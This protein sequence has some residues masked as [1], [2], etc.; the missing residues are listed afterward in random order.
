MVYVYDSRSSF[1]ESVLFG[2]VSYVN[3]ASESWIFFF[4]PVE[5]LV[6]V[7]KIVVLIDGADIVVSSKL[8]HVSH[9]DDASD[10]G[11]RDGDLV[12]DEVFAVD[13][14]RSACIWSSNHHEDSSW[15]G[16]PLVKFMQGC[17]FNIESRNN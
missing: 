2:P 6:E 4:Q 12:V 9:V 16:Q 15:L 8:E 10:I 7:L 17:V 14:V 5:R 1:V 11:A 13:Q 3:D